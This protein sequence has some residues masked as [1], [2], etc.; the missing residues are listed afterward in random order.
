MEKRKS[1]SPAFLHSTIPFSHGFTLIEVMLVVVIIGIAAGVVIPKFK[2]TFESTQMTDATRSTV[3]V[4]RYARSLSILKQQECT[5]RFDDDQIVLLC[6]TNGASI[7]TLRRLPQDIEISSFEN[8]AEDRLSTDGNRTVRFYPVGMNDG[9]SVTLS[10]G[11]SRRSTILCNPVSG[12][13]T[14]MEEGR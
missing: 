1:Y 3:R 13:V 4:A 7:D 8:L 12:K 5:L 14:V 2:G 9:F 6:G 10:A 11:G